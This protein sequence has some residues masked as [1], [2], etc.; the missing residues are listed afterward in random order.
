MKNSFLKRFLFSTILIFGV[1]AG[2]LLSRGKKELLAVRK[3]V[4]P[5]QVSINGEIDGSVSRFDLLSNTCFY[6]KDLGNGEMIRILAEKMEETSEEAGNDDYYR[7]RIYDEKKNELLQ[8]LQ[9]H[10]FEK[11]RSP[12][13]FED[14]NADG[15]FDLT[16]VDHYI[17]HNRAEYH[18]IFSPSKR[19]FVKLD[20]ELDYGAYV[21]QETRRMYFH[22][23]F[24]EAYGLEVTYQWKNEMDYEVIKRFLHDEAEGG[25]LVKIARY[26]D[27]EEE[28]LSNYIYSQEEYAAR[29]DI[30][31][32]YYED[33][34]WEKEVT[35]KS[36]GEKYM[37][38]YAEVFQPEEA[39][40][41][42]GIYYDGRI[43][44]YDEDTY[45]VSVTH[46]EIVSESESIEWEDGSD[47][48]EQA[49]VIHYVDGGES[50]FYLSGLIQPDYQ[51][52]E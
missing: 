38:R 24:L 18:Y 15:Y 4:Y 41:N 14:F 32:T 21:D 7:V 45:L 36:T 47:D 17:G 49:L 1:A 42:N 27:G 40:K 16:V 23:H 2:G 33:F 6:R 22:F 12:F 25:V 20:S 5:Q 52:A 44:V 9:I 48:R 29:D 34:I 51:A 35:D 10:S 26:E 11:E 46:S 50:A 39:E 3:K 13:R 43:F 19:E 28:F 31:E 30:S 37:I 8:E